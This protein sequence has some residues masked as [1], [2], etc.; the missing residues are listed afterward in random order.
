MLPD[1][2][3]WENFYVILGSSGAALT[4]LQFVVIALNAERRVGGED[5]LSAFGTPTIVHFCYVLLISA[6]IST[7][8]QTAISL[9]W[10]LTLAGIAALAY[11]TRVLMLSR[12]QK[13]YAPVLED[14]IFHT[15]LPFIAYGGLFLAGVAML[16]HAGL[17]LYVT[18]AIALLL[19]FIGIH[20]AWDAAVWIS[21]IGRDQAPSP[22]E[23]VNARTS[24]N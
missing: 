2:S 8:G 13:G 10:C 14:W 17:A 11:E 18:A 21:A 6:I 7:P 5:A 20:N 19:L 4:G 9:S 24:P 15:I 3:H 12:R 23:R 22:K 16:V 1:L